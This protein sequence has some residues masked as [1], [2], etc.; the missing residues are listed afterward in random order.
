[1]SH[2]DEEAEGYDVT[3]SDQALEG[4]MGVSSEREGPTGPDQFGATGVRDTRELE[5]DPDVPPER[6]DT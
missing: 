4:D 2:H 1:M 3:E 6:S 5:I